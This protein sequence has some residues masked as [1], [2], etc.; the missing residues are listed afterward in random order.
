MK[1]KRQGQLVTKATSCDIIMSK[2]F[3]LLRLLKSEVKGK[4]FWLWTIIVNTIKH[5]VTHFQAA[6]IMLCY[7]HALL[8]LN[9]AL[10]YNLPHNF[11]HAPVVSLKL[12]IRKCIPALN[13]SISTILCG[14]LLNL[15]P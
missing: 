8:L 6:T 10:T 14:G 12:F 13:C 15:V 5:S 1:A 7:S 4:E 11:L 9:Y 3:Q 2:H